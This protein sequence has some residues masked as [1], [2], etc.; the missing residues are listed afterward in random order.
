[1]SDAYFFPFDQ[2]VL[3]HSVAQNFRRGDKGIALITEPE[4]LWTNG[5]P[6]TIEGVLKYILEGVVRSEVVT[7]ATHSK[8]HIGQTGRPDKSM[9]L[10]AAA[11]GALLGGLILI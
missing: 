8:R 5:I 9:G 10:V 4:F 2:G 6:E 3:G 1:M 7:I 11:F